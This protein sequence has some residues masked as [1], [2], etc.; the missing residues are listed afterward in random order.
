MPS[1]KV[2]IASRG[3]VASSLPKYSAASAAVASKG[4]SPADASAMTGPNSST[5]DVIP[6]AP[7]VRTSL[8][9]RSATPGRVTTPTIDT[10]T[11]IA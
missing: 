6:K 1:V 10:T 5:R 3:Q 2:A 11:K 9:Y 4:G 8:V 7:V